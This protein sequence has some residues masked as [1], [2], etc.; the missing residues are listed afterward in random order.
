MT[1]VSCSMPELCAAPTSCACERHIAK[2]TAGTAIYLHIPGLDDW[3]PTPKR[4]NSSP[5]A[6]FSSALMS[7]SSCG[8]HGVEN[9]SIQVIGFTGK[10]LSSLL[11]Y[12]RGEVVTFNQN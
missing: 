11:S 2:P 12:L 10:V 4:L 1:F 8:V 9:A 7:L 5:G 6:F 3:I